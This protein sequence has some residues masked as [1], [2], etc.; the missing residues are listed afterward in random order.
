MIT[1]KATSTT[2][3]PS[4]A[5]PSAGPPPPMQGMMGTAPVQPVFVQSPPMYMHHPMQHPG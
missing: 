3:Y 2:G 1:D 4:P 5:L